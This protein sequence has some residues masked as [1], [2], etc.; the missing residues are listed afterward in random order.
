MLLPLNQTHHLKKAFLLLA[1]LVSF[2]M[3]F[4]SQNALAT[5]KI[6]QWQTKGGASVLYVHAPELPMLDI[7]VSFDAGSARDGNKWGLASMTA[8]LLGLKTKQ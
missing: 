4:V 3:M 5:I 7:Q 8:S 2:T 6:E 1:T